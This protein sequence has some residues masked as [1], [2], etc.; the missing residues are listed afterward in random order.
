MRIDPISI[1]AAL[2]SHRTLHMVSGLMLA[3]A[4]ASGF[5]A[6]RADLAFAA[7]DDTTAAQR[8]AYS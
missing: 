3:A 4:V 8:T 5:M 7:G 1:A 2:R 6:W